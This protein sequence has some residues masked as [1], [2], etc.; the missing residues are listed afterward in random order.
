MAS[1]SADPGT[2]RGAKARLFA[3]NRILGV[4]ATVSKHTRGQPFASLAPYVA[5]RLGR[6]LFLLSELAVHTKNLAED[7]RASLFVFDGEALSD[8]LSAQRMNLLGEVHLLP[9]GDIAAARPLY[10]QAHPEAAQWFD[11]GDFALYRLSVNEVYY[12]GGFGEMGWISGQD[13]AQAIQDGT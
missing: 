5:D 11:F 7:P 1:G 12:V 2:A 13:Y 8:P 10:L 4:L 3:Q 6:P 9:A